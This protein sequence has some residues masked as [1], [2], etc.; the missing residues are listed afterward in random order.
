MNSMLQ[1]CQ[2]PN[3]YLSSGSDEASAQ[4]KIHMDSTEFIF[5]AD[6]VN[7]FKNGDVLGF[8]GCLER[9]QVSITLTCK[10][11]GGVMLMRERQLTVAC[12][13]KPKVSFARSS[14]GMPLKSDPDV[15][16]KWTIQIKNR[17]LVYRTIAQFCRTGYVDSVILEELCPPNIV[18]NWELGWRD[19]KK[20][21]LPKEC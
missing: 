4:R 14:T 10:S 7:F 17:H 16:H 21:F 8:A 15:W 2:L 13:S 20:Y 18:P 5:S 11:P 6:V 3:G 9:P 12:Q 19:V 1:Q